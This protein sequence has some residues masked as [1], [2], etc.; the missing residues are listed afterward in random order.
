[1]NLGDYEK[2]YFVTNRGWALQAENDLRR[3][4]IEL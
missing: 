2:K 3:L 1:M 4:G